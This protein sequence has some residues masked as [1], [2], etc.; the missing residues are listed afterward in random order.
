LTSFE[1]DGR[2]TIPKKNPILTS[3]MSAPD[4]GRKEDN[5]FSFSNF[6][7]PDDLPFPETSNLKKKVSAWASLNSCNT[8]K[9]GSAVFSSTS[10]SICGV[11]KELRM[12][13]VLAHLATWSTAGSA[14]PEL[15]S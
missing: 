4:P 8:Q 5:P 1:L 12:M 3:K 15:N 10:K 2:L 11:I 13:G 14:L 7:A 6:G 9:G